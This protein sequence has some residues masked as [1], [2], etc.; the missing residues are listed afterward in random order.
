MRHFLPIRP[1]WNVAATF[2]TCSW[3]APSRRYRWR[4]CWDISRSAPLTTARHL[5]PAG[6]RR[7]DATE[8][9]ALYADD[10]SGESSVNPLR[11]SRL[12]LAMVVI[13]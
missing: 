1:F 8:R 4:R 10:P 6:A 7:T 5:P 12:Y 3:R 11:K 2:F 9:P 13:F